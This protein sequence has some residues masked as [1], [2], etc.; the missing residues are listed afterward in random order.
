MK[1]DAISLV[2][3]DKMANEILK[4]LCAG[5]PLNPLPLP[6]KVRNSD[7][8]HAPDRKPS[9]ADDERKVVQCLFSIENILSFS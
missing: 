2:I 7:V 9:L 5:L 8:P 1:N 6:K 3:N 4:K